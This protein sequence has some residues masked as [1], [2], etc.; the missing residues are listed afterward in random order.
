MNDIYVFTPLAECKHHERM[1]STSVS[2][3]TAKNLHDKKD[4]RAHVKL[5]HSPPATTRKHA[6]SCLKPHMVVSDAASA[7]FQ[8]HTR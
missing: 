5:Q 7:A 1:P 4:E 2:K 3:R 8:T 6:R